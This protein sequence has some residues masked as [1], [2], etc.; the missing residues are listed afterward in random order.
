MNRIRLALY[1]M[2]S[3]TAEEAAEIARIG[4]QDRGFAIL[5]GIAAECGPTL[6]ET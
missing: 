3:G 6:D 2:T 4:R 5:D 1:D